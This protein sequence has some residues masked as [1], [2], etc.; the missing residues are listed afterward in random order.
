METTETKE[1]TK[2]ETKKKNWFNSLFTDKEWDFD[3]SKVMGFISMLCGFVA[4]F[5]K[6]DEGLIMAMLGFGAG[7]LGI[8]KAK[9]D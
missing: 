4:F 3:L 6:Y 9:G 7:L 8:S 2:E 1:E 5:L